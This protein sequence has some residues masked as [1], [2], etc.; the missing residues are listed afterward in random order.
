MRISPKLTP[1]KNIQ[2]ACRNIIKESNQ[3]YMQSHLR[4]QEKLKQ[5]IT[6]LENN[7]W[8]HFKE[9]RAET[10][11]KY[12]ERM[13]R[14]LHIEMTVRLVTMALHVKKFAQN[15]EDLKLYRQRKLKILFLGFKLVS[16][17]KILMKKHNGVH[18]CLKH[19]ARHS[20]MFISIVA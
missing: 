3:A 15:V 12:I 10:V 2:A 16:K 8:Q 9:R 6:K 14:K 11:I 13:K 18:N 5:E 17:T 7:R 1:L 4:K 20:F 19:Q